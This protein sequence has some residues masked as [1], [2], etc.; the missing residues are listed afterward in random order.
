MYYFLPLHRG[1]EYDYHYAK[2]TNMRAGDCCSGNG[3]W[4]SKN[5]LSSENITTLRFTIGA[6]CRGDDV[7]IGISPS[8]DRFEASVIDVSN[9][10]ETDIDYIGVKR[11][12]YKR[13]T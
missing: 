9:L 3:T 12:N 5:P 6:W 4:I 7:A 2:R 10:R 11:K 8:M 13:L 1:F